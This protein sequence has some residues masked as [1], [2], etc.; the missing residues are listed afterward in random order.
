M[1]V[2]V[3]VGLDEA[4]ILNALRYT[5]GGSV[6]VDLVKFYRPTPHADYVHLLEK[7]IGLFGEV[8]DSVGPRAAPSLPATRRAR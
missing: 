6:M 8:A 4:A 5:S 7:D 2:G 1:T 3:G